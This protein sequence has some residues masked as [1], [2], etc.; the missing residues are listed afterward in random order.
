MEDLT[1]ECN[2]LAD[3]YRARFVEIH[4]AVEKLDRQVGDHPEA[5]DQI[6]NLKQA[7]IKVNFQ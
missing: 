7:L 3:F 2:T 4:N 5:M 1:H 6:K